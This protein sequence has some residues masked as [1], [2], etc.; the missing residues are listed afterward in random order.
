MGL[1]VGACWRGKVQGDVAA[2]WVVW[3][4]GRW[5]CGGGGCSK[6]GGVAV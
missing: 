4:V 5:G 2:G 6:K 3:G 1:R